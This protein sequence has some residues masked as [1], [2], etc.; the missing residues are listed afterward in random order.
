MPPSPVGPGL[1][2]DAPSKLSLKC[3][4]YEGV[5]VA[6]QTEVHIVVGVIWILQAQSALHMEL[7]H[8]AAIGTKE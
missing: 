4:G 7:E 8:F 1:P 3:L 6:K 2:L 5:H